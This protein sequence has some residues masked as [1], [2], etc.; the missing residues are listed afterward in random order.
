MKTILLAIIFMT[1]QGTLQDPS[2]NLRYVLKC[3]EEECEFKLNLE[4]GIYVY[5]SENQKD[6]SYVRVTEDD[7]YLIKTTG[8]FKIIEDGEK[9]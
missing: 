9:F 8:G 1:S 5:L 4:P 6:T 2:T 3:S 7:A